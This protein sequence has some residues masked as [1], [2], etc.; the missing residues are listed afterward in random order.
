MDKEKIVEIL[1]K[2]PRTNIILTYVGVLLGGGILGLFFLILSFMP[3]DL[4]ASGK[5]IL[6]IFSASILILSY[7]AVQETKRRN[8]KWQKILNAISYAPND[9]VWIYEGTKAA[10]AFYTNL[11]TFNK[12][13]FFLKDGTKEFFTISPDNS[14]NIIDYFKYNFNDICLGWN[15]NN[16]TIFKEN[17]LKL[18]ENPIITDQIRTNDT[19]GMFGS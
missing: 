12:L 11:T 3:V 4:D 1:G 2:W 16:E 10:K 9:I 19:S 14:K 13:H 8:Y 18:T 15:E 7:F 5:W 6:R 17:P